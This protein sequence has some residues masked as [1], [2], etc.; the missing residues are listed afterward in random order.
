MNPMSLIAPQALLTAGLYAGLNSL[1]RLPGNAVRFIEAKDTTHR[2]QEVINGE[3]NFLVNTGI[4][5]LIAP[6]VKSLTPE[7]P[8]MEAA[9]RSVI[10]FPIA[11]GVELLSRWLSKQQHENHS[12]L[13]PPIASST[14]PVSTFTAINPERKALSLYA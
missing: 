11:L 2:Q 1:A 8:L 13:K 3:L 5:L 12:T 9:L 10:V 7:K 6:I 14:E 4:Q